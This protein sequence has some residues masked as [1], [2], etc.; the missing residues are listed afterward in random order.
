MKEVATWIGY[1]MM[2]AAPFLIGAALYSLCERLEYYEARI[3]IAHERINS[4]SRRV[5]ALEDSK[6]ASDQ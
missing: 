4:I 2:I 1:F 6:D 3:E 5:D